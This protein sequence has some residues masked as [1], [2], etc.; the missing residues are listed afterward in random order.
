[1]SQCGVRHLKRE[2]YMELYGKYIE[3]RR[4]HERYKSN[5][6]ATRMSGFCC[7]REYGDL[8]TNTL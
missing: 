2:D 6:K 1:M 4:N 8:F 3:S 5:D 7:V